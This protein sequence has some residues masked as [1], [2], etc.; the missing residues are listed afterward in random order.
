VGNIPLWLFVAKKI[1]S[2]Y[3]FDKIVITASR[4]ELPYMKNFS[5]EFQF[6][7]G[8]ETRQDSMSNALSIIDSEHVMVTDVARTCVPKN[9]IL[10]LISNKDKIGRAH[11]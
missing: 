2:Y 7:L 4:D 10:D 5:D 9:V 11:V 6:V 8:G 1:A 3:N